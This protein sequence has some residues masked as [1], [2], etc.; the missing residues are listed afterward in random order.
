MSRGERIHRVAERAKLGDVLDAL[1]VERGALA[2]G[3]VFVARRRVSDAGLM[4]A[5]GDEVR[6]YAP[7]EATEQPFVVER[8]GGFVI[9]YKPAA[10]PTEPDRS[11]NACLVRELGGLHAVSRLDVGV[12][13]LVLLSEDRAAHQ[14]AVALR[15]AGK[16]TR[17]YLGLAERAPNPPSGRVGSPVDGKD[18][19]SDY[20]VLGEASPHRLPSGERVRP[21]LVR[22]APVTGRKHQLRV[23]LRALG[24]P[25]LG[26]RAHGGARRL[27]AES[28]AVIEVP[29]IMLHAAEVELPGLRASLPPPEDFAGVWSALLGS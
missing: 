22:L 28:G 29:R 1:L 19:A 2:E 18:A 20:E 5:P 8:A 13:G 11:G 26:D 27:T 14:R 21:A 15:D 4:L 9:A 25:L 23:H 17:I 6:V 3:R 12:S 16:I 24:A 10:L 7:R